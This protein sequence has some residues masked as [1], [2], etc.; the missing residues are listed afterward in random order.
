MK[1]LMT[2]LLGLALIGCSAQPRTIVSQDPDDRVVGAKPAGYPKTTVKALPDQP[3]FCVK[4]TQ[5]WVEQSGQSQTV[6]F[7]EKTVQSTSCTK[8]RWHRLARGF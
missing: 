2:I 1:Y 8:Q 4:V 3:G 5:D 7:K 6:W